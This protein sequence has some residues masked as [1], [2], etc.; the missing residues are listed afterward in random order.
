MQAF[1]GLRVVDFTQVLSGPVATQL[2]ALMGAEVIKIESPGRGDQMRA[3]LTDDEMAD[4]LLSPAFLTVN[5]G[6]RS[7]ALDLADDTGRAVA[8]KLADTADVVVENFR[9]GVAA[10]LGIDAETIRAR[11][12]RVIYCSISGYG[13]DGPKSG[14]KAYDSAIQAD[15]GLM[16]LTGH[17]ETGPTRT[18]FMGVDFMTGQAAAFAIAS[19]LLRRER[20]GEGQVL[21]V[22]MMD[23]AMVMMAPQMADYLVRGNVA[24]LIG[25]GSAMPQPTIGGFSTADG[26]VNMVSVTSPQQEAALKA[27]GLGDMLDDPRFAT[28]EARRDNAKEGQIVVGAVMAQKTTAEWLDILKPAGVPVQAVRT[29]PE[30]AMDAQWS[31]RG[32]MATAD[33]I[34]GLDE[35]ATLIGAP[36]MADTDG[37]MTV[38]LPPGRVG[39]HTREVLEELGCDRDEIAAVLEAGVD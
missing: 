23:A 36:F 31:Y 28:M 11:N 26:F 9:P 25:N 24:G 7:V 34:E 22:A 19:A 38:A 37:P 1:A 4:R 39:Q 3:I 29:L 16:T 6:K 15:S 18:G 2:L 12:S 35:T 13:Q 27:L 10:K 17:P 33:G 5:M 21:D 32:V 20:T 30:V 8:L 14:E